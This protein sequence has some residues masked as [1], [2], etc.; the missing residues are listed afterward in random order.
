MLQRFTALFPIWAIIFS[1]IA[2][3]YPGIFL[4][5]KNA[6]PFLLGLVMFGMGMTLALED[7]LLVFKRPKVVAIEPCYSMH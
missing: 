6:I 5:Y 3:L 2:L 7:F 1:V 4:P